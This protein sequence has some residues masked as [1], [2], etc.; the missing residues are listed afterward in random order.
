MNVFI[1]ASLQLEQSEKKITT[2]L[3][4]Y[5]VR[6]YDFKSSGIDM[7]ALV[8]ES[9]VIRSKY[10]GEISIIFGCFFVSLYHNHFVFCLAKQAAIL[11]GRGVDCYVPSWFSHSSAASTFR[12]LWLAGSVHCSYNSHSNLLLVQFMFLS[13]MLEVIWD[14]TRLCTAIQMYS[15]FA[16]L[17]YDRK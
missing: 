5:T 13:C 12:G 14:M 17:L 9:I 1:T 15:V 6:Q 4:D 7:C 11:T 16:E 2:Q 10:H 8:G 3:Q